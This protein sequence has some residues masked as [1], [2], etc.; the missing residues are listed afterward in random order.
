MEPSCST[1]IRHAAPDDA[2]D[3]RRARALTVPLWR[4]YLLRTGYLF[5]AGGILATQW[6]TLLRHDPSWPLMEG[7][8]TSML[9]AVSVLALLGSAPVR[10]P[11]PVAVTFLT[12]RPWIQLLAL[13]TPATAASSME[14]KD[15][16]LGAAAQ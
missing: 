16:F 7:V 14:A 6:P 4:L 5:V 3:R 11:G 13:V 12:G 8:K 9:A 10:T 1:P 15:S 2:D